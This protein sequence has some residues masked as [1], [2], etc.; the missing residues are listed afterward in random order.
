[1]SLNEWALMN[2]D[3]SPTLENINDDDEIDDVDYDSMKGGH[4]DY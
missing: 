3:A 2:D 1:M 4:D